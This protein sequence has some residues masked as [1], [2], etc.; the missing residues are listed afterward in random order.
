MHTFFYN[1]TPVATGLVAVVLVL[2]LWNMLRRG[3][4]NLSQQLMR[5]RVGLQFV[6]V[7]VVM[8]AVYFRG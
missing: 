2:G 5:W 3:S 4:P 8:A 6:A 1:L 7:C